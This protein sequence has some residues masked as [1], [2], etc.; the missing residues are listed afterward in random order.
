MFQETQPLNY[1]YHSR[2]S[3]ILPKCEPLHPEQ[4]PFVALQASECPPWVP[5]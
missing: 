3:P 2:L 5:F 4:N 1:R